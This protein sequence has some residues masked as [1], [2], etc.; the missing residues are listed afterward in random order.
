MQRQTVSTPYRQELRTRVLQEATRQFH[1]K[2]IRAVK[3]DDIAV[4]LAISKRTLYELFGNKEDLA[5]AVITQ[6]HEEM[7]RLMSDFASTNRS[8]IDILVFF[9]RMNMDRDHDINPLFFEDMNKYPKLVKY[10]KELREERNREAKLFM[11]TGVEQGYF[12]KEFNYDL[13]VKMGEAIEQ[14]FSRTH[15]HHLYGHKEVFATVAAVLFRGICTQKGLDT[16]EQ[17]IKQYS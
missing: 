7:N 17:H 4:A 9:F 3:M 12:R 6:H 15:I 16:L 13:V 5:L 1:Q 11:Q 10:F 14:Y 8:V 2:G